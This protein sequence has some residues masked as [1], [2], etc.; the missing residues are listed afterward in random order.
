MSIIKKYYDYVNEMSI[1]DIEIK[2]YET[3]LKNIEDY[4][5]VCDFV[6]EKILE[7]KDEIS[8]LKEIKFKEYKEDNNTLYFTVTYSPKSFRL[9]EELLDI[10]ETS[11]DTDVYYKYF[12]LIYPDDNKIDFYPDIEIETTY[13]NRIHIPVG[14]PNILK[15]CRLGFK[16]YKALIY[17]IGYLSTNTLDRSMDSLFVWNSLRKDKEIYTFIRGESVLCISP[18]LKFE[19][20]E[21]LLEKFFS[22]LNTKNII[23]DDDFKNKYL[24]DV[25]ESSKISHL[26]TYQK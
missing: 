20:I 9:I 10:L 2:K 17:K 11:K 1:G 5:A 18:E 6:K 8:D 3:I 7:L 22:N 12:S 23:L 19:E 24:A 16:I 26:L 21:N 15:G 25:R 4:K 14:L 13:L